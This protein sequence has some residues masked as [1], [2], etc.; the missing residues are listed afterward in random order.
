MNGKEQRPS[1]LREV[2]TPMGVFGN[3]VHYEKKEPKPAEYPEEVV[4][5]IEE[6]IASYQEELL[7]EN[8]TYFILLLMCL[9]KYGYFR[10]VTEDVDLEKLVGRSE[11]NEHPYINTFRGL[12]EQWCATSFQVCLVKKS[13]IQSISEAVHSD[14]AGSF[15]RL[16]D[17]I[18]YQSVA[19]KGKQRT[20]HVL[21]EELIDFMT[22]VAYLEDA[23]R[24]YNPFSGWGSFGVLTDNASSYL[25]QDIEAAAHQISILRSVAYGRYVGK[26]Y[27]LE[28]TDVFE[29]WPMDNP[30]DLIIA[31]PPF[32]TKS[33]SAT[34]N[35][36]TLLEQVIYQGLNSLTDQGRLILLVPRRFLF[37]QQNKRVRRYLIKEDYLET[38]L[39]VV[40]HPESG[41]GVD[42]AV[43]VLDK[44]KRNPREV[45]MVSED[46][47]TEVLEYKVTGAEAGQYF[48]L[49]ENAYESYSIPHD[50]MVKND[51]AR[52]AVSVG[53]DT[54]AQHS[55]NLVPDRYLPITEGVELGTFCSV[56]RSSLVPTPSNGYLIHSGVLKDK[57][58]GETLSLEELVDLPVLHMEGIAPKRVSPFDGGNLMVATNTATV[59]A[60]TTS[61]NVLPDVF[62]TP[63][64]LVLQF[65]PARIDPHYLAR[66]LRMQRVQRQYSGYLMGGVLPKISIKDFL[67]IRVQIPTLA[68]QR[69]I[70]QAL[71]DSDKVVKQLQ[72]EKADLEQQLRFIKDERLAALKHTLGAPRAS[73]LSTARSLKR[74]ITRSGK[75]GE[76]LNQTYQT[77][78][79]TGDSIE[80]ALQ[81]VAD[82]INL[83][84]WTLERGDSELNVQAYPKTPT[85][86]RSIFDLIDR[87]SREESSFTIEVLADVDEQWDD[88]F[89]DFNLELFKVL[90][91]NILTNAKRYGFQKSSSGNKVSIVLWPT[92]G[93]LIISVRNNGAPLLP[94]IN[95]EFYIGK[96]KSKGSADGQGIGGYQVHEIA[97]YFGN[98]DWELTSAPEERYPVTLRFSFP[99]AVGK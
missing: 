33:A 16:F 98:P 26:D 5:L 28:Q 4:H 82:N 44:H 15:A 18:L 95:K 79:N 31:S 68:E 96:F 42:S 61:G 72:R 86:V 35:D 67:R 58:P 66:E 10:T 80:D 21:P 84:S 73:I 30:F 78:F 88:L 14:S 9:S 59:T 39:S 99:F 48:S 93:E 19:R 60:V 56:K 64:V 75:Q 1:K 8:R 2:L 46:F 92:D 77:L 55:Y 47:Y 94:A 49:S 85:S 45:K 57:K 71:V 27:R 70:I 25:G 76:D 50:R 63:D 43:I 11:Y 41:A 89:L 87:E 97:S 7:S 51:P 22:E 69:Q 36:I 37:D 17:R 52:S 38:V 81:R 24:V 23:R 20:V 74:F 91:H 54:L 65:D 53:Y 62:V 6:A 12:I 40:N 32:L 90:L 29:K 83:I 34:N 3:A 13:L